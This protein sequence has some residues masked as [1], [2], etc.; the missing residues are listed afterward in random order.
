[1]PLLNSDNAV[2][3]LEKLTEYVLNPDH[4]TGRHKARVFKSV[5]G[6]TLEDAAFL[7]RTLQEI[8]MTH[9]ATEQDTT[10]YGQ[11]FVIDFELTTAAGSAMVR[12]AW[13]VRID[14]AFPRLT[15]CYVL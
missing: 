6:L 4:P 9:E 1:M 15:S 11:R 3:D 8:V 14:E 12:S 5:L 13:I 2:V 10:E 7:Q